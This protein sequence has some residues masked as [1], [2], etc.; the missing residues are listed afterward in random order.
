MIVPSLYLQC[1]SVV[2]CLC[3]KY[4]NFIVKLPVIIVN[5]L[6]AIGFEDE[7]DLPP[8]CCLLSVLFFC[9]SFLIIPLSF[10]Y[11]LYILFG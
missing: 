7:K 6:Y 3:R 1:L 10:G 8:L 2:A 5:D 4:P 9:F 11:L